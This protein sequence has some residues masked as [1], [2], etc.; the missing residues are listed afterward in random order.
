MIESVQFCIQSKHEVS[1]R[2]AI[3][4][5]SKEKTETIL[6]LYEEAPE[7]NN[8]NDLQEKR[9]LKFYSIYSAII[10][11]Q[12]GYF[13]IIVLQHYCILIFKKKIGW[14][15]ENKVLAYDLHE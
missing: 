1:L 8:C 4:L 14:S 13:Q 11:G 10:Q 12:L 5:Q 7:L 6:T 9:N 15:T 3:N 2:H